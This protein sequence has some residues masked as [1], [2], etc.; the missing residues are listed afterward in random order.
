MLMGNWGKLCKHSEIA[1]LNGFFS[2]VRKKPKDDEGIK[3]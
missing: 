1:W 2:V 3:K